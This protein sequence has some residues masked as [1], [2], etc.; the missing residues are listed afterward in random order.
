MTA[1]LDPA[2]RL[3]KG[4]SKGTSKVGQVTATIGV[5]GPPT[6]EVFDNVEAVG[7]FEIRA[8]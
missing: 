2:G 1:Q 4:S 6:V 3:S 8:K 5:P 7:P